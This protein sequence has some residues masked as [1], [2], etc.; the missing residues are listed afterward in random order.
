MMSL[1]DVKAWFIQHKFLLV[2]VVV[3]L[4]IAIVFFLVLHFIFE[5]L[6]SESL[7]ASFWACS[8][9]FIVLMGLKALYDLL[10]T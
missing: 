5:F 1:E 3:S 7:F 4:V 8:I 9:C 6:V 2:S 10:M